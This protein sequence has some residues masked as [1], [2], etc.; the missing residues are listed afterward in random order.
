MRAGPPK[1][2][3]SLVALLVPPAA[4]EHVLGDLR[5]RFVN[6]RSYLSDAISAVPGAIAGRVLRITD[7]QVLVMEVSAL[8]ISFLTAAWVALGVPYL[9]EHGDF[10][11]L[12]LPVVLAV[13]ALTVGDVY[14]G[15]ARR[16]PILPAVLGVAS[17]VAFSQANVALPASI[18]FSGGAVGVV[19]VSTLRM[20]FPP[21][22]NRPRGEVL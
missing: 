21:G 3:E 19:L 11:R 20:W 1:V 18:L 2:I 22:G 15:R 17:G 4:R 8:Y 9:F 7:W 5:E 6:S 10:L 12:L 16:T 14:D 13:L